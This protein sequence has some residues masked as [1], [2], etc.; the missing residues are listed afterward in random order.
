MNLTLCKIA[1]KYIIIRAAAK[2]KNRNQRKAYEHFS[3]VANSSIEFKRATA[4][5][6]KS[7][8]KPNENPFI[9][10][11]VMELQQNIS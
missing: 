8:R 10:Y 7:N 9:L 5:K 6:R 11:E 3:S 1:K 4:A 2:T